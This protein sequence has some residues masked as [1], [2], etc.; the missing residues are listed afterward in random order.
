MVSTTRWT[1]WATLRF[2]FGRAQLSVEVFAGDDVGGG[3]G[4]ID[5]DFDVAL[6][7]DDCAFVVA[8][9]GGTGLPLDFVV[10]RFAGLLA[11]GE[12]TGE[13]NARPM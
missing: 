7:E 11:S 3:L 8:D 12:V 6:F 5:G 4:P 2:A 1:S 9:G 10:R 13:G